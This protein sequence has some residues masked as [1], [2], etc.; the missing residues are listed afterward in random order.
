MF[1]I[2]PTVAA[3]SGPVIRVGIIGC[4]MVTQVVH[5]P[6]LNSLSHLFQ[7]TYLYDVSEDAMRHSQLKV[8]GGSKPQTA[9]S[10]EELCAA[11]VV[12]L[13][14]IAS[15]DTFHVYHA[16]LAL[17]AN[18]HVF[19]EKPI[20]LTLED[21]DRIIDADKA[22][23]CARVFIGYMRRYAAAFVDAVREVGSIGQIRYARVRDIIGPNSVFVGQSGVYPQTFSDY[24]EE[25]TQALQMMTQ[26][27]IRQALETELGIAVTKETGMMWEMLSTL[28]SHDLSA[29]R[30]IFGMPT[31]VVGFSPCAT[32]GS[33]FWS[34]IFQYPNFAVAYESGVDQVARFDASIEI[35]GDTKTVKLCIDTP[36]IKGLPTTMVIKDSLPDGSY[37][38]STIRRTYED[39]FTL[40]LKEVYEWVV[41][42]KTPKTGPADARKDLEILGMLMKANKKLITTK[43]RSSSQSQQ[44]LHADSRTL[45]L[46]T[47]GVG[48]GPIDVRAQM[49]GYVEFAVN[50]TS[51]TKGYYGDKATQAMTNITAPERNPYDMTDFGQTHLPREYEDAWFI[52]QW[53]QK[54]LGVHVYFTQNPLPIGSAFFEATGDAVVTDMVE[55]DNYLNNG[56][57]VYGDR[58][59]LLAGLRPSG[60]GAENISRAVQYPSSSKFR[61]AGYSSINTISSYNGDFLRQQG[62]V[63]FSVLFDA[64]H[65]V[66]AYQP[67]TLYQVF[68]HQA[69]FGRD[70]ATGKIGGQ[71]ETDGFTL[72]WP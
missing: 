27:D 11:A 5:V 26:T 41:N 28:G 19:I 46:G 47:L 4:G 12:D 61:D 70:V 44:Q 13:V 39:P 34:A 50:N 32:T 43:T 69:M 58:D 57:K 62:N 1:S 40:E 66:A 67:E 29:M 36:F 65:Q 48:D 49:Q 71:S 6:T 23:G 16:L 64:G 52:W 22:A 51:S 8:A 60:I 37:R 55:L 30:E 18:K 3:P 45:P 25:D 17:Q 68:N 54:E 42:G 59:S 35:F 7:V 72:Q 2:K 15:N 20:A 9:Q 56:V 21:T 53:V 31:G 33:P 14:I 38:E 24:R 10:V 63:A